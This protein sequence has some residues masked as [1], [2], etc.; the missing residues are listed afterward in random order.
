MDKYNKKIFNYLSNQGID[1]INVRVDT[2]ITNGLT[3][4]TRLHNKKNIAFQYELT[5]IKPMTKF[6]DSLFNFMN[7]LKIGTDTTINFSYMG[8]HELNDPNDST[9]PRLK[10]FAIPSFLRTAN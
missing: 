5:F 2:V 6:Y 4:I 8:S 1:S 10:V 7:G 9:L 3:I